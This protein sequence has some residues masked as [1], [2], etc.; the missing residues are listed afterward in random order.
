MEENSDGVPKR[1][2][3]F[4][5]VSIVIAGVLISGAVIYNAGNIS[6]Q[7][8]KLA[9]DI[10]S[11]AQKIELPDIPL[12]DSAD[13]IEGGSNADVTLVVYTDFECPYCKR[14]HETIKETLD[15][16]SPNLAVVYRHYPISDIHPRALKEAEASECAAELGG[17]SA[18]WKFSDK[19]FEVTPS[20]NGL[21][22]AEL[23]K[24]AQYAGV[25]QKAFNYCLS[26]GKYAVKVAKQSKDAENGGIS[27]SPFTIVFARGKI[28]NVIPG[29]LP[30][31]DARPEAVT[32][33]KIVDLAMN[34]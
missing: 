33:R 31:D 9:A 14:F 12:I 27:G 2:D 1:K 15:A 5:P 32:V 29:A 22:P 20:N 30:L 19:I 3:Y 10:G 18:F 16:Y 6:E 26:S 25:E 8:G 13:H 28:V 24:I 11:A 34:K 7:N 21:D 17:S 23:P 4:L